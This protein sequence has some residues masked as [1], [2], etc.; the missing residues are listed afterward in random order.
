MIYKMK[1]FDEGG[2][3]LQDPGQGVECQVAQHH[4]GSGSVGT[5]SHS[6]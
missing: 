5:D 3:T 6:S 1:Y 2:D 4:L